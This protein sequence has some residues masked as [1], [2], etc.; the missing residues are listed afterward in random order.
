VTARPWPHPSGLPYSSLRSIHWIDRFTLGFHD[1]LGREGQHLAHETGVDLLRNQLEKQR[2]SFVGHHSQLS[3]APM[4]RHGSFS[5]PGFESRN[6]N[7][8]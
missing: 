4:A 5:A 3:L 2:H 1:K 7:P 6:Q 8:S